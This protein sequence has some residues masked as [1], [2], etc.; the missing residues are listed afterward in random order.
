MA[1]GQIFRCLM[2]IHIF[3]TCVSYIFLECRLIYSLLLHVS[4]PT[5]PTCSTNFKIH[6][7]Y[8]IPWN[9]LLILEEIFTYNT[10]E[11]QFRPTYQELPCKLTLLKVGC[12]VH[13]RHGSTHW[14]WVQRGKKKRE[15]MSFMKVSTIINTVWINS[16]FTETRLSSSY[17]RGRKRK[18]CW[19][20]PSSWISTLESTSLC[21]CIFF[22][23]SSSSDQN[24]K[25]LW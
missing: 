1:Y 24:S 22:S 6:L 4:C 23:L 11:S 3:F 9:P 18:K 13:E 5:K 7:H 20:G 12:T 2:P 17:G 19:A 16:S 8:Y 15:T 21:H 14:L 10:F 25:L